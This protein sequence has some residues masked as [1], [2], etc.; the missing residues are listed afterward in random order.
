MKI[1]VQFMDDLSNEEKFCVEIDAREHMAA[2]AIDKYMRV[3]KQREPILRK[4]LIGE[5][6]IVA[7]DTETCEVV[8]EGTLFSNVFA[9]KANYEIKN[10]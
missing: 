5:Y 7:Y 9:G 4:C 2:Q 3:K 10:I 8:A 6:P 1:K